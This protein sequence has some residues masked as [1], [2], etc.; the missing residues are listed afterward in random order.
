MK[1]THLA[2]LSLLASACAPEEPTPPK[3][4]GSIRI[5]DFQSIEKL[6]AIDGKTQLLFIEDKVLGSSE[7]KLR[8]EIHSTLSRYPSARAFS[9]SLA[10]QSGDSGLGIM[11]VA[12]NGSVI[13]KTGNAPIYQSTDHSVGR[14]QL[15]SYQSL[16]RSETGEG[17]ACSEFLTGLIREGGRNE[18]LAE[19]NEE[20]RRNS[21]PNV[22]HYVSE[23]E[24]GAWQYGVLVIA[25]NGDL[26]LRKKLGVE[27]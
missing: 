21:R 3:T 7:E 8:N 5:S 14:A 27:Y 22:F 20:L 17:Q 6:R 25:M 11:I 13:L 18:L 16:T 19:I 10:N 24:S 9:Y 26:I 12:A 15:Y 4:I 1:L 2:L 23:D